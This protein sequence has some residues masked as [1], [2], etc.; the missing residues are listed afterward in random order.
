MKV[1][2]LA[3]LID[4]E[5]KARASCHLTVFYEWFSRRYQPATEVYKFH[6]DLNHLTRLIFAQAQEPFTHELRIRR[7]HDASLLERMTAA[8]KD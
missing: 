6:A 8:A 4:Q 3:A 7:E 1:E 5:Q 2:D